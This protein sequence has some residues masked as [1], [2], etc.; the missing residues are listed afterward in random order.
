M[1]NR[2][3]LETCWKWACYFYCIFVLLM[4][5]SIEARTTII[6]YTTPSAIWYKYAVFQFSF[7]LIPVIIFA[8]INLFKTNAVRFEI[9]ILAVLLK[10]LI[11]IHYG[12]INGAIKY[13]FEMFYVLLSAWA[14][15]ATIC[16]FDDH[17][18]W[19]NAL[20]F[21]DVYFLAAV[22]TQLLRLFLKMPTDGRYG[23]LRLS[24]GGTG[25]LSAI[26]IVYLIYCR[27]LGKKEFALIC[28]AFFSLLLSGQRTNML[29]CVAF[30]IP[31]IVRMA[32]NRKNTSTRKQFG[33]TVRFL[34]V[35]F[36]IAFFSILFIT[37]LNGLGVELIR[38][39]FIDR[40]VDAIVNF[41]SGSMESEASVDGRV[42]SIKA[43][44]TILKEHPIGITN[45]FYDLQYR[46]LRLN[47][48]T[49]PHS[50]LLDCALLWSTPVT[51]LCLV[52]IVLLEIRLFRLRSG[53][54]YVILYIMA[55]GIIWGSPINDY[56]LLV[57]QLLFFGVA[58]DQTKM[59]EKRKG[60]KKKYSFVWA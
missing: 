25:Y 6:R 13:Q 57:V 52:W 3:Q 47:Y 21:L 14:I 45:D 8:V 9:I 31:I 5:V 34:I 26:Y 36:S 38:F 55:L 42:K 20:T 35:L 43:G 40:M 53:Y 27:E 44:L 19:K 29:F 39:S 37:L 58:K 4:P 32:I 51:I 7:L 28:L 1:I 60:K 18:E 49:F 22:G 46:M 54:F 24:V 23:A 56:P 50:S 33:K 12:W 15:C 48:P 30:C 11:F 2:N 59:L 17:N 10:D 41:F 16:S